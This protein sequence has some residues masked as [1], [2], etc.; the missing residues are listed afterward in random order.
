MDFVVVERI[1]RTDWDPSGDRSQSSTSPR[2]TIVI[3]RNLACVKTV[4]PTV[5]LPTKRSRRPSELPFSNFQEASFIIALPTITEKQRGNSVA[6]F[7]S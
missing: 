1:R 7:R 3:D 2:L 6:A 4:P 5:L